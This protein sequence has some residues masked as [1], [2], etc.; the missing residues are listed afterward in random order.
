[1][2]QLQLWYVSAAAAASAYTSPPNPHSQIRDGTTTSN[3]LV[4]NLVTYTARQGTKEYDYCANRGFCDQ[5]KGTT[6]QN[7][8]LLQLR[9]CSWWCSRVLHT[10][11]PGDCLCYP[12]Y[13]TS[14][15]YGEV[16]ESGDCGHSITPITS[17]PGEIECSGHG[18]CADH[19]TYRCECEEGWQGGDCSERKKQRVLSLSSCAHESSHFVCLFVPFDRQAH[20]PLIAPGL[21]TPLPP[22]SHMP[23]PSA[24][25]VACA[26][27]PRESACARQAL[28]A[29]PANE[30]RGVESTHTLSHPPTP[31]M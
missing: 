11:P 18:N 15:L 16:G 2:A 5:Q 6:T 24:P 10:P 26:T 19:P 22:T 27:A 14:N 17:C 28:L 13:S 12:G 20:A 3:D 30:V 31:G 9:A 1:M 29:L 25:T 23:T 4:H 21:T 8:K 7:G